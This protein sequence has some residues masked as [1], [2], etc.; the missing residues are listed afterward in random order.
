[1]HAATGTSE[2]PAWQRWVRLRLAAGIVLATVF[3]A[4]IIGLVRFAGE[5]ERRPELELQL[6]VPEP[7]EP[8]EPVT[9]ID[10]EPIPPRAIDEPVTPV[11][12]VADMPE[13]PREPRSGKPVPATDWYAQIDEVVAATVASQQRVYSVNPAF[14]QKRRQAALKFAPSRAPLKKPIWENVETDQ[15]GRKIL[16][17]GDCHRVVDD[18][19]AVNNEIFRTFQQYIVYCTK[20]KSAPQELPW[21]EEI[22]DRYDYLRKN[23]GSPHFSGG[24]I[25]IAELSPGG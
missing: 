16:V 19:S 24:A 15:L 25:V 11:D 21:T 10:P 6:V 1:M 3:V 12:A 8:P 13:A 23:R 4:A 17:S 22:R 2:R 5:D 7:T 20:G 9:R 14:D 18:P